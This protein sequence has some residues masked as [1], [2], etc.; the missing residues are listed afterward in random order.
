MT[1]LARSKSLRRGK[2]RRRKDC[3]RLHLFSYGLEEVVVAE[4][5]SDL[6]VVETGIV[7]VKIEAIRG[8][9]CSDEP[10]GDRIAVGILALNDDPVLL[11]VPDLE[12]DGIEIL[13][14]LVRAFVSAV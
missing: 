9:A 8:V 14:V 2:T 13:S 6:V 5:V 3:F 4:W 10:K 7:F 1:A 11:T 12:F